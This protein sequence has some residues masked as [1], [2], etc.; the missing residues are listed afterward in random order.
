LH[1]ME[2]ANKFSSLRQAAQSRFSG[3]LGIVK[4]VPLW[5]LL[6]HADYV[7]GMFTAAI[8]QASC[9]GKR[10]LRIE[11]G[12]KCEDLLPIPEWAYYA[13]VVDATHLAVTVQSW[14]QADSSPSGASVLETEY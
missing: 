10:P 11:L 6:F 12:V 2:N 4:D 9:M 7:A 13:R 5:E 3:C 14:L 8:L 1:P